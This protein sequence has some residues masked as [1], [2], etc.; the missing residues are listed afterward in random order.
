MTEAQTVSSQVDVVVDPAT[1]FRA[2][3]PSVTSRQG[4]LVLVCGFFFRIF[5]TFA[6]FA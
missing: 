6:I 1:A 4:F 3:T 5:A 2:F